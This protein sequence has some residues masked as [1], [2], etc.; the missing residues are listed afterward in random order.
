MNT[1]LFINH[2]QA[3]CGVYQF[4]Q[5]IGTAISKSTL[6]N[7]KY[8]ECDSIDELK[9]HIYTYNP[10]VIIYN[11][12]PSTLGWCV[13]VPHIYPD[14]RHILIRH[15]PEPWGLPE[16]FE[17][18]YPDPTEPEIPGK[19]KTGRLIDHYINNYFTPEIPTFGSF[20]F[21]FGKSFS[22][23]IQLIE[24]EYDQAI[25]N[26]HI[27]AAYFG[28]KNGDGARK[29]ADEARSCLTKPGIQLNITHDFLTRADLVDF[30][31]KNTAN[32]FCYST[33]W[34][35]GISSTLDFALTARR[36][37][38]ITDSRQFKHL[39][40]IKNLICVPEY[41]TIR[42]ILSRGTTPL[43]IYY[44]AWTPEKLLA[45]YEKIISR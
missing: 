36:P 18:I 29:S 4:G 28:D 23:A 3:Q 9:Q 24:K 14:L 44:K 19:W 34:G 38:I 21:V 20:G 43:Q 1:I 6:F 5:H 27:P 33:N 2:K 25:I 12:Y 11:F 32:I 41:T 30:L 45:T 39:D 22:W 37:I 10:K 8:L 15:E 40:G 13:G 26:I 16:G 42:D 35:R 31:A 7:I 17:E